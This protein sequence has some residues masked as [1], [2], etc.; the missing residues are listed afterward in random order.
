MQS[1]E[2]LGIEI[3]RWEVRKPDDLEHVFA[4]AAGSEAVL[5]QWVGLTSRLR[6]QIAE[7]AMQHC[8]PRFVRPAT[9]QLMA[10]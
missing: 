8:C 1:A 2:K 6:S 5:V 7:L 10:G 3:E 9:S 4:A